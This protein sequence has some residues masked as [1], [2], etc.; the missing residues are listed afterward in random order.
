[1]PRFYSDFGWS[2]ILFELLD[3]KKKKNYFKN[4]Y[5]NNNRFIRFRL[6]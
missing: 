5:F 1:M 3:Y 6:F 4:H 2:Y